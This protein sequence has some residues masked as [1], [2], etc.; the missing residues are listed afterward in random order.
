[1]S[2][3]EVRKLFVN[4]KPFALA[5]ICTL[6]A[7]GQAA[8]KVAVI[9]IQQA[10]VGTKEGQKAQTELA[11]MFEPKQKELQGKQNEIN[12]KKQALAASSNTMAEEAKVKLTREIDGMAKNLQRDAEDYEA[13]L[14]AQ[15][16]KA[17]GELFQKMNVVIIRY[18]KDN[19]ISL[20]LDTS[21]QVNIVHFADSLDITQDVVALY[22][23]AQTTAPVS[24]AP[25]A[26]AKQAKAPAPAAKP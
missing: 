23:R 7:F 18:A 19:N 16:Q 22:D 3:Q 6:T 26:P 13:M 2:H 17:L 14:N 12:S 9:N 4:W 10:I 20:V 24:A 11:A 15:Q 1:V 25:A 8:Q 21:Q 5:T